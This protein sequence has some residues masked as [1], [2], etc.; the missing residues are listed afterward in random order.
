VN[1]CLI[2]TY[3][4]WLL[5]SLASRA[6]AR[7]RKR[8]RKRMEK[9]RRPRDGVRRAGYIIDVRQHHWHS[10]ALLRTKQTDDSIFCRWHAFWSR[11]LFT[12]CWQVTNTTSIQHRQQSTAGICR[13]VM[14]WLWW[15]NNVSEWLS[16]II[17]Q[18]LLEHTESLTLPYPYSAMQKWRPSHWWHGLSAVFICWMVER[19]QTFCNSLNTDKFDGP[20][21]DN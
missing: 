12:S 3:W 10:D 13:F 1:A 4:P 9:D 14:T 8:S 16:V 15:F 20:G 11:E 6:V 21:T 2:V 5:H 19:T 17:L 7:M 18:Q